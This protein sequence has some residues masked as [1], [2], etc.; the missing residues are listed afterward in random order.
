MQTVAEM[1]SISFSTRTTTKKNNVQMNG[2]NLKAIA[3]R[4]KNTHTH[5]RARARTQMYEKNTM[6][7]TAPNVEWDNN[8]AAFISERRSQ[9]SLQFECMR[10]NQTRH[11]MLLSG[12]HTF[13][14][15]IFSITLLIRLHTRSCHR[16]SHRIYIYIYIVIVIKMRLRVRALS[17]Q[18]HK[19]TETIAPEKKR[20]EMRN[21]KHTKKIFMTNRMLCELLSKFWNQCSTKNYNVAQQYDFKK[22]QKMTEWR[23]K[24]QQHKTRNKSNMSKIPSSHNHSIQFTSIKR[25]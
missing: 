15:E 9:P 12:A 3:Q 8:N 11:A 17:M 5:R 2:W 20:D 19:T 6:S 22:N 14:M 10:T 1:I 18:F 23:K 7:R 25:V 16:Y 4:V 21:R 13:T 24:Q